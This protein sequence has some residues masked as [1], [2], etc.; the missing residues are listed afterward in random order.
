MVMTGCS[1][2]HGPNKAG[3]TEL[4]VK[5]PRHHAVRVT[6]MPSDTYSVEYFRMNRDYTMETLATADDVYGDTLQGVFERMT[7][8]ATSLGMVGAWA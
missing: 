7:G 4:I 3:Q 2:S 1:F 6:L 5:L 8:L